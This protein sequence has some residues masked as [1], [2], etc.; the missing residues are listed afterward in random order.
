MG[1]SGGGFH[2]SG[3][4]T[5]GGGAP[6]PFSGRGRGTPLDNYLGGGIGVSNNFPQIIRSR[7]I[8]LLKYDCAKK[9][10]GPWSFSFVVTGNGHG[11]QQQR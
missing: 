10:N 3:Q 6:H 5:R 11:D 7:Q 9:N 2:F 4:R 1:G 8:F